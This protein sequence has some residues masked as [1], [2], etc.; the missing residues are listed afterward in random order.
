[1]ISQY[2]TSAVVL[3]LFTLLLLTIPAGVLSSS[4]LSLQTT[5]AAFAQ[6]SPSSSSSL[7]DEIIDEAT[8]SSVQDSSAD[9][10]VLEDSNEFGDEAAAIE[11]HNT[12]NQDAAGLGLQDQ[13][14][15]QELEEEQ[16]EYLAGAPGPH[17]ETEEWS[18]Y[19]REHGIRFDRSDDPKFVQEQSYKIEMLNKQWHE[20]KETPEYKQKWRERRKQERLRLQLQSQKQREEEDREILKILEDQGQKL[21][22]DPEQAQEVMELQRRWLQ[23]KKSR[24]E[25]E[26]AANDNFGFD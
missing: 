5:T 8:T 11:Q 12:E 25:R 19:Q 10:N 20:E 1:L 6:Q 13:D 21:P 4:S 16:Q 26:A 24:E 18:A 2:S 14:G 9:E 3:A 23:R 7:A 22:E 17:S 15:V